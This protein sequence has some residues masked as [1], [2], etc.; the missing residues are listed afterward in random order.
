M[1]GDSQMNLKL[2]SMVKRVTDKQLQFIDFVFEIERMGCIKLGSMG[3][4]HFYDM[5]MTKKYNDLDSEVLN[6]FTK[7]IFE[8][9]NIKDM[10]RVWNDK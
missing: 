1:S 2:L 10:W 5:K 7:Q 9:P 4:T 6:M 3:Y 8:Q